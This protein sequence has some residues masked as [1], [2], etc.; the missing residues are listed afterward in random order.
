MKGLMIRGDKVSTLLSR[1]Q[2]FF[3]VGLCF[4]FSLSESYAMAGEQKVLLKNAAMI[5]TMDPSLGRGELG[6]IENGDVLIVGSRIEKV[7]RNL[8]AGKAEIVDMTGR[9][10]LPGF[11]DAHNHLWT[12]LFRGCAS[13][14]NL[15]DWL[16]DCQYPLLQDPIPVQTVYPGVRLSTF[17][18]LNSGITTTLDWMGGPS[19]EF[20]DNNL[21]ALE[22]SGMRFVY[23]SFRTVAH[24]G[25]MKDM[26]DIRKRLAKNSLGTLQVGPF[27]VNQEP[28]RSSFFTLTDYAKKHGLR[29][30]VHLRE[31]IGDM[32]NE[33]LVM[34]READVLGPQLQVAHAIHLSD[35]ELKELADAGVNAVHNPLSNMRIASGIMR[36]N[37]LLE[38]GMPVGL[39]MDG[40]SNDTSDMFNTMRLAV[41]LQRATSQRSD[42]RPTIADALRMATIGGARVLGLDQQIGSLTPGKQADIIALNPAMVNFAPRFDWVSQIVF[43]AQPANVEWVFVDGKALKRNG[44]LVGDVE[45]TLEQAEQGAALIKSIIDKARADKATANKAAKENAK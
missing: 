11:V 12:S 1:I 26:E 6:L 41:G 36:L 22:D 24:P 17:D 16:N 8:K 39:G 42:I 40:S 13:D 18:L 9:I 2:K 10:L 31:N 27:L 15:Y 29:I 30:H 7:G 28:F 44:E 5:M 19:P 43:N 21:R 20:T 3:V 38:V 4:L 25:A 33:Q 35:A 37:D 34:L 14:G 45:G 32:K 23:S